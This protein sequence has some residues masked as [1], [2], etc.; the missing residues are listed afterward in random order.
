ML[1]KHGQPLDVAVGLSIQLP[2]R[3]LRISYVG[4]GVARLHAEFQESA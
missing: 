2:R 1:K 4:E 3:F